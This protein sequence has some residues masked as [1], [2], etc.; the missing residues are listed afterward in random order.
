MRRQQLGEKHPSVADSYGH[1][2]LIYMGLKDYEEAIE[3][4]KKALAIWRDTLG[5]NHPNLSYSY[6]NLALIY[7]KLG[8][9][10]EALTS[11][12][13]ALKIQI[14]KL[15][16]NHPT[17]IKS[18]VNK[19]KTYQALNKRD[20]AAYIWEDTI[21]NQ[22]LKRLNDTYLFLP[23]N[24]RLEYAKTFK[25]VY[26]G[27]YSFAAK[28]GD[29]DTK[30]LAAYLLF[31]T[32]SLAL[33]YSISVRKLTNN[34]GDEELKNLHNEL[35]TINRNIS[36]AELMTDEE[37]TKKDSV[38]TNLRNQQDFLTHRLLEN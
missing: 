6:I 2:S 31:N 21:I 14:D 7:Y 23:D 1:R 33:D 12:E 10:E 22:S 30:K 35:N 3:L 16:K 9:Y 32:K 28:H 26:N 20:S 24:Q 8:N 17:V 4:N 18:Y 15:G 11:N 37:L 34:I 38:L 19:A 29:E 27:F 13:K 36:Q 5:K 25:D